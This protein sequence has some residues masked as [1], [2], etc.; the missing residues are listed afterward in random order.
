VDV[1]RF[2]WVIGRSRDCGL[3]LARPGIF[4]RH[5]TLNAVAGEGLVVEVFPGALA[6][7]G[8]QEVV[9]HRIRHGE[10]VR[11]GT[12]SLGFVLAP[13]RRRSLRVWEW[14]FWGFFAA[15]VVVQA[16]VLLR[17]AP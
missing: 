14:L 7:V 16:L 6:W 12:V 3:V 5:L 17:F 2:P 8:E 13:A 10:V 1:P 4:D 9:R 15:M 11:L